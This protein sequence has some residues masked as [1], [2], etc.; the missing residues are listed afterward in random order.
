VL[1]KQQKMLDESIVIAIILG[2][3]GGGKTS[4]LTN[5]AGLLNRLQEK[6]LIID[7]DSQGNVSDAFGLKLSKYTAL[8]MFHHK[9]R[10]EQMITRF[11]PY[12]DVI[13]ASEEMGTL[14]L[15][16]LLSMDRYDEPFTFVRPHVE[17]VRADYKYVFLDSP[18]SLGLIVGNALAA[19]DYVLIP[20]LPEPFAVKG[21][22]RVI[23][24]VKEFQQAGMGVKILAVVPM[25]VKSYTD[26]HT[27]MLEQARR[28]CEENGVFMTET[29]IPHSILFTNATA[30]E[31]LPATMGKDKSNKVVKHYNDLWAELRVRMM[32]DQVVE[33]NGGV[34]V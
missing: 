10:T 3:G 32:M 15:D 28:Y 14:E 25:M 21:L 24:S 31:R 26:V 30:K 22:I 34:K 29:V 19:S 2:K 20:F 11:N 16:L 4:L 12:L 13:Q 17:K 18:P 33:S 23:K 1:L 27:D 6:S 5:L 7:L 8:N 9:V